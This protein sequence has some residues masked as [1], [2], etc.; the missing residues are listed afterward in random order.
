[1]LKESAD[2][3]RSS[4]LSFLDLVRE[5]A[6]A[7]PDHIIVTSQTESLTY[8]LLEKKSDSLAS[9]LRKMGIKTGNLVGLCGTLSTSFI[10]C[11]MGILKAGAVYFPLDAS[12]PKERLQYIL[13]DG[14]PSAI[15]TESRFR[16][17]F[18]DEKSQIID[19]NESLYESGNETIQVDA[20]KPEDLA[21]VIYTSG[22]TGQPKGI[23]VSHES[24][25]NIALA[26]N[27]Y[28][29]SNLRM[30]ISG[31][32]CFDASLLVIFHALAN[33][34][35]LFLFDYTPTEPIENLL[36]FIVDTSISYIICVP[37]QYLQILQQKKSLASLKCVS[38][39]G[40]YLCKSLCNLHAE[41]ASNSLLYNEY[42]PSECAIGTTIAKIYDPNH[43]AIKDVTVGQA[44]P[45]TKVWILDQHLKS[46]PNGTKGEICISGIGL[47]VG[48]LNNDRLTSEKFIWKKVQ[49]RK[50]VR[51]YRSGD[52]GRFLPNGELEFLG[53][54]HDS[55][56][57][58]QINIG[59]IEFTISQ[60]ADVLQSV[61]LFEPNSSKKLI[62]YFTSANTNISVHFAQFLKNHLPQEIISSL[63]QIEKF[64][65]TPN[66]KIDRDKLVFLHG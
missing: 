53:R 50:L 2:K 4:R 3:K 39:T 18:S 31:G 15:L 46:V 43:R 44:L 38:L 13:K 63:I 19:L 23:M 36:N 59:E 62:I 37:S 33:K 55:N 8:R 24:L 48:Y 5:Q 32:V 35:C 58:D 65:L 1:M 64:P 61:A 11:L 40:E 25:T 10:V 17:L 22:S 47:A 49:G 28:Y 45:N 26:H 27:N 57:R 29:P 42:G 16:H 6:Y 51:L 7:Y 56:L 52:Q 14:N 60:Y 41:M 34:E 9:S 54:I 20:L 30:L 21:Y 66:G 12:Y